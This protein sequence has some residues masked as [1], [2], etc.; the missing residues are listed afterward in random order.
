METPVKSPTPETASSNRDSHE[1]SSGSP[2]AQSNPGGGIG[3]TTGE[4]SPTC[5][6]V[7]CLQSKPIADGAQVQLPKTPRK[8]PKKKA[9]SSNAPT[10]RLAS[11]E[12]FQ[13]SNSATIDATSVT[14]LGGA[15]AALTGTDTDLS[16]GGDIDL[17]SAPAG[18][19]AAS[20][21][22][23]ELEPKS[24]TKSKK[25]AA[26]SEPKKEKVIRVGQRADQ[27]DIEKAAFYD[28]TRWW[29][30]APEAKQYVPVTVEAVKKDLGMTYGVGYRA[31]DGE[32]FSEADRIINVA[33]KA[34]V[35]YAGPLAGFKYGQYTDAIGRKYLVTD[36][37][38]LLEGVPG[39]CEELLTWLKE[40]FLGSE[41]QL[42]S[43]LLWLKE[44]RAAIRD[45]QWSCSPIIAIVGPAGCGKSVVQ[46]V[47]ITE[48]LGGRS[49]EAY[50][51]MSG[52]R[53]FN[54]ELFQNEH[55]MIQD[56]A[57]NRDM[58]ARREFGTKIKTMFFAQ[59]Q[60]CHAKGKQSVFLK[61]I[62]AASVTLNDEPE[63][64]MVLPP[65]DVS[66]RDK[67]CLYKV[68]AAAVPEKWSNVDTR[69][70]HAAMIREQLP[71]LAHF[72]DTLETPESMRNGRTGVKVYHHPEVLMALNEL[73]TDAQV[74]YI[75]HETLKL[76]EGCQWEGHVVELGKALTTEDAPF[77]EEVRDHLRRY[78]NL[79]LKTLQRLK[80]E[81]PKRYSYK[82]VKGYGVWV[83]K[84]AAAPETIPG[85]N[86][87]E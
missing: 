86:G 2:P 17:A 27:R 18:A 5:R 1:A 6:I 71:H 10:V 82:T 70:Q 38:N 7:T 68:Q 51:A 45:S 78:P 60:N 22:K 29:I 9:D 48:L 52:G 67:I 54:G 62:W 26:V 13:T 39:G 57:P 55:L 34:P 50:G 19:P 43:F 12:H 28:G 31:E 25:S 75:I 15:T 64:L 14:L 56:S 65:L 23:S 32:I 61:P 16:I 84:G 3:P 33:C 83:I 81:H 37:A 11:D 72:I 42:Y 73:S 58:A 53:D 8:T 69:M 49:A 4:S 74:E 66:L 40:F 63:N 44:R 46:E 47:L 24:E 41:E 59:T 21:V 20:G 36:Q 85:W 80:S 76:R 87:V 35:H 79:L 30:H 77:A